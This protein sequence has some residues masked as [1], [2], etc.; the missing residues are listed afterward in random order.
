MLTRAGLIS[1]AALIPAFAGVDSALAEGRPDGKHPSPDKVLNLLKR[2]NKRW[3]AGKARRKSYV[4]NEPL[5]NGQWPIAAVLGCADS[6]VQPDELFDVRPANL[7]VVRNA[8][9]VVDEDVL[10]SLEY[11]IEHLGVNLIVT[12]GHQNCGAVKAAD[13]VVTGGSMPGG[14]IDDIVNHI[15]P[16]LLPLAVGHTI[17]EAVQA[18]AEQ[19]AEQLLSQS[20]IL[21]EAFEA[22]HLK[23]VSGQYSFATKKVT[24]NPVVA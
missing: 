18:N 17:D 11:A 21:S 16:A 12:L 2:G 23:I 8:G 10:G 6:R 24:Y 3:A 4:P 7:F 22:G 1:A 20:T 5:L 15:K 9:N 13:A 14:H 19:S